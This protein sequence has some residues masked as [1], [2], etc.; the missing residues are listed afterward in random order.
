MTKIEELEH[1]VKLLELMLSN[2]QLSL[3]HL[4]NT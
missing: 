3:E 2:L 1:R 4:S